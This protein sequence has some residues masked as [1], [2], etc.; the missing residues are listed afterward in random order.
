[1][2][3]ASVG[4]FLVVAIVLASSAL[5]QSPRF[6]PFSEWTTD[7]EV[8]G[9]DVSGDGRFVV[10]AVGKDATA[11][12]PFLFDRASDS[13]LPLGH[14]GVVAR[15][16]ALAVAE[17]GLSVAGVG[18]T[19]VGRE[20]FR[21]NAA[22]GITGLG[23]LPGGAIDSIA[24]DISADGT[25]IV[26]NSESA[27][28]HEAFRWSEQTGMVGLGDMPGGPFYSEARAISSDGRVIVG[29][30]GTAA[31]DLY[32]AY[33][34]TQEEGMVLLGDLSGG[35]IGSEAYGAS[36]DGSVIVGAG[37]SVNAPFPSAEA[38][39]W[40]KS[41]GMVGL[42]DL[43]GDAF[44]SAALDVS[45]DGSIVVG[46]SSTGPGGTVG[47]EAFIWEETF[48]MRNLR[49]V[50]IS[51]FGLSSE[52]DGWR[53]HEALAISSDGSVIV[54]SGTDPHG[55]TMGWLAEVPEPSTGVLLASALLAIITPAFRRRR[56]HSS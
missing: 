25:V 38:F 49:E 52:L 13:M 1:M 28:G 9:G 32:D 35:G 5:S 10:G 19:P 47:T 27:T 7:P 15:T 56:Q 24:F 14:L 3:I 34:W 18:D 53:L 36:A 37:Y 29:R 21:W 42:G 20:A 17:G 26:G 43:P 48:G 16:S 44:M 39:R 2:R 45:A 33:F 50:L 12:E 31:S 23:D 54:G 51:D 22:D 40:T 41:S 30:T 55:K 8:Y 46:F 6:V 4:S 11:W